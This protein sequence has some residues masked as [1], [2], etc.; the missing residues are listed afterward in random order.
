MGIEI[1][2]DFKSGNVCDRVPP[3]ISPVIKKDDEKWQ[4][5]YEPEIEIFPDG[6][7]SVFWIIPPL[8]NFGIDFCYPYRIAEL[9]KLIKETN[10]YCKKGYYRYKSRQ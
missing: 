10:E 8:K 6:R 9:E 3:L 2:S 5:L 1:I 7:Y 4:R